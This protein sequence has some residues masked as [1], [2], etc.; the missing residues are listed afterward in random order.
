MDAI[1]PLIL[2]LTG[3]PTLVLA[4]LTGRSEDPRARGLGLRWSLL[5]LTML[6][7]ATALYWAGDSRPRVYS[8]VI[9]LV[10]AANALAVSM[11]RH[12]RRQR[13]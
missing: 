10:V 11:L 6:L 1:A 12:L 13:R 2:A 7:G 3:L 9:V 5:G 4:A 8:V